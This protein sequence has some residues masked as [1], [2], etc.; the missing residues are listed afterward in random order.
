MNEA[1][2][3]SACKKSKLDS[4]QGTYSGVGKWTLI[5]ADVENELPQDS[6]KLT[7]SSY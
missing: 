1:C 2:L 4:I 5:L 6:G 7:G 3:P